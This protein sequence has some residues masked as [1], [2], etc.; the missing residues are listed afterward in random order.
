MI[1]AL[2]IGVAV[3]AAVLG[4]ELY[5]RYVEIDRCHAYAVLKQVPDSADLEYSDVLSTGKYNGHECWFT[6][7]RTGAPFVLE[8]DVEDTPSD[9][10]HVMS[11]AIPFFI[12]SLCGSALLSRRRRSA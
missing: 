10:P 4:D 3:G 1:A 8:F 2:V 5:T 6:N 7:S 11:M 9:I 12:V